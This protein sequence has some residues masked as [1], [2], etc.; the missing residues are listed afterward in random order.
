MMDSEILGVQVWRASGFLRG[1]WELHANETLANCGV[2]CEIVLIGC[3]TR[4]IH[5]CAKTATVSQLRSMRGPL[6]GD[7]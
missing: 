3:G 6:E 1:R 7:M 4:S 5:Q 2:P